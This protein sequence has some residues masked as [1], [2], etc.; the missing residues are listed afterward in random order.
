MA[1]QVRA[2]RIALGLSMYAV[3]KQARISH[4]TITRIE[5]GRM[6]PTLDML[7]RITEAMGVALWPILKEAEEKA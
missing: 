5:N 2:K 1:R 7:L 4:S 3:A 6:K